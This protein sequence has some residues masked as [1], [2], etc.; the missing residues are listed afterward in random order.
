MYI[1][2]FIFSI[3]LVS[4]ACCEVDEPTMNECP[5]ISDKWTVTASGYPLDYSIFGVF[6]TDRNTGYAYGQR[7]YILKSVNGGS[8]WLVIHDQN[9][10]NNETKLKLTKGYFLNSLFGYIGGERMEIGFGDELLK[11]ALLLK[12]IDGGASWSKKYFSN[13]QEFVDFHFFD[14]LNGIAIASYDTNQTL[15]NKLLLTNN[16]GNTW[17]NAPIISDFVPSDNFEII[18]STIVLVGHGLNNK[19]EIM[20]SYD[21]GFNWNSKSLPGRPM[22][23][24]VPC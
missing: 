6:F 14:E 19:S 4:F 22:F 11:G 13:I 17:T 20:I 21:K 18:D 8:S 15:R 1:K 12:T 2:L 16:G 23:K 3:L 10:V 7:G 24:S 9:S 5:P